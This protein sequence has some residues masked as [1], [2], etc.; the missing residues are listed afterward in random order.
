MANGSFI[1]PATVQTETSQRF[2]L[3]ENVRWSRFILL[4]LNFRGLDYLC[5]FLAASA[6]LAIARIT[7]FACRAYFFLISW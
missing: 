3:K 2:S 1:L 4:G 5:F 6:T 7:R